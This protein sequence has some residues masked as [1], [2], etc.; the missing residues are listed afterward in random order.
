MKTIMITFCI[1]VMQGIIGQEQTPG[2]PQNSPGVPQIISRL[3]AGVIFKQVNSVFVETAT[4][5]LLFSF[6]LPQRIQEK[7][8]SF[9]CQETIS[10]MK[11]KMEQLT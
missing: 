4:A 3:N 2:E 7:N 10:L 11:E 5:N 1:G 8:I 9:D 6:G